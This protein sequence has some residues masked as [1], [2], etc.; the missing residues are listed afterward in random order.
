[1]KLLTIFLL[2]FTPQVFADEYGFIRGYEKTEEDTNDLI[3][4][5]YDKPV[6]GFHI[7]GE[8][9]PKIW[10]ARDYFTGRMTIYFKR[11]KDKKLFLVEAQNVSFFKNEICI[12]PFDYKVGCKFKNNRILKYKE[13]QNFT[14][15]SPLKIMDFDFDGDN[16][17]IFMKASGYRGGQEFHAYEI[18]DN[19]TN[20]VIR[21]RNSFYYHWGSEFDRDKKTIFTRGS[22]GVCIA[23][24]ETY[25]LVGKTYKLIK[26]VERDRIDSLKN[27]KKTSKCIQKTYDVSHEGEKLLIKEEVLD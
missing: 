15:P 11:I 12:K 26:I 25:Q 23:H 7:Q 21:L 6:K 8:F 18:L 16:E 2:L 27:E 3:L 9:D 13:S 17:I 19:K 4:F 22:G 10:D 1:M 5:S 20:K 14:N 24:D